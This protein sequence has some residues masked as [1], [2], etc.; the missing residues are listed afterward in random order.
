[1][2]IINSYP[3]TKGELLYIKNTLDD[4]MEWAEENEDISLVELEAQVSHYN[5]SIEIITKI[6]EFKEKSD[7]TLTEFNRE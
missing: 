1:M 7:E 3:I 6:L 2:D 4:L 5:N